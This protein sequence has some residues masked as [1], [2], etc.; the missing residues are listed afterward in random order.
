[1]ILRLVRYGALLMP[2]PA[3]QT[4]SVVACSWRRHSCGADVIPRRLI[5]MICL[6]SLNNICRIA[7]FDCSH[8]SQTKYIV[9]KEKIHGEVIVITS[10]K[11]EWVKQQLRLISV[12]V[13]LAQ[14]KVVL[15]DADIGKKS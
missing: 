10:G 6:T 12:S 5:M 2:V 8:N 14:K 1:M 11:A 15:I 4:A 13:W 3:E 9:Q 7:H